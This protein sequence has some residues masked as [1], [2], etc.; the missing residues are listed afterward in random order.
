MVAFCLSLDMV[1]WG[2]DCH[3]L[4]MVQSISR[5]IEK[6]PLPIEQNFGLQF[7]HV[8]HVSAREA[9]LAPSFFR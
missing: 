2:R 9:A 8:Q 7:V 5:H 4:F 6:E 1:D 3:Q